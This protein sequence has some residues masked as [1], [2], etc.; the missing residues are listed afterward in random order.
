MPYVRIKCK[1][2]QISCKIYESAH[3]EILKDK[4]SF[5]KSCQILYKD[6]KTKN[7]P[8]RLLLSLL[9]FFP[10]RE[11]KPNCTITEIQNKCCNTSKP[12]KTFSNSHIH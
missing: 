6:P 7:I 3:S 8:T 2:Y 1:K 12:K 9:F 10:Q 11:K 4:K 5:V